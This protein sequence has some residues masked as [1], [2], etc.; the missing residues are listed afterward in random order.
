MTQ[1]SH[2][3]FHR[4]PFDGVIY[5]LRHLIMLAFRKTVN[6]NFINHFIGVRDLREALFYLNIAVH[7]FGKIHR[8]R[9]KCTVKMR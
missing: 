3:Q 9:P 7:I 4:V 2:P 6:N 1:N 5:D 8:K